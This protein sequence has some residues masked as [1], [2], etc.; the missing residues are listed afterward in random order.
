M[1]CNASLYLSFITRLY[2]LIYSVVP[3]DC[4]FH[5][6]YSLFLPIILNFRQNNRTL[7]YNTLLQTSNLKCLFLNTLME[8]F[9]IVT[10]MER[11]IESLSLKKTHLIRWVFRC[12]L[13]IHFQTGHRFKNRAAPSSLRESRFPH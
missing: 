3:I 9:I 4:F 8:E 13:L 2:V 6:A 7:L 1:H 10:M 11:N 12:L 5:L